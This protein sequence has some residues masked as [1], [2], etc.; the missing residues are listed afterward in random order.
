VPRDIVVPVDHVVAI[1]AKENGQ[2]MAFPAPPT[3]SEVA[4]EATGKDTAN[5]KPLQLVSAGSKE[6]EAP[7]PEPGPGGGDGS[8]A[9]RP[10]L[11]RVK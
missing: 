9:P 1:Y 2:G 3:V 7:P 8:G 11:K 5:G 4:P 10:A 6:D